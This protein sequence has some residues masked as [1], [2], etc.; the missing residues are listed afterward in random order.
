MRTILVSFLSCFLLLCI[1]ISWSI[2]H[3]IVWSVVA[4]AS[5]LGGFLFIFLH[6]CFFFEFQWY[7]QLCKPMFLHFHPISVYTHICFCSW[8][9]FSLLVA[10]S[11]IA[12]RRARWHLHVPRADVILQ[13][14]GSCNGRANPYIHLPPSWILGKPGDS[15]LSRGRTM[16]LKHGCIPLY[17]I[18]VPCRIRPGCL[19]RH[20]KLPLFPPVTMIYEFILRHV[21]P[22][23]NWFFFPSFTFLALRELALREVMRVWQV[24]F[25]WGLTRSCAVRG[26]CQSLTVSEA[27]QGG[28][29]ALAR[30]CICLGLFLSN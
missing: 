17:L 7:S 11:S 20:S 21:D 9:Q 18:S 5:S 3:F 16:G 15:I 28:F 30:R 29:K 12:F 23:F 24:Q 19:H 4:A 8:S 14:E 10:Q 2:F 22:N 25:E 27:K 6:L 13:L 26:V 1:P